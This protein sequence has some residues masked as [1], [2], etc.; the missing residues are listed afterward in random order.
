MFKGSIVRGPECAGPDCAGSDSE[1]PD[2]A[3]PDHT[4]T[5]ILTV[6]TE[7]S[8]TPPVATRHSKGVIFLLRGFNT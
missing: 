5:D 3:G 8:G 7:A 1:G 4:C 2:C 6:F